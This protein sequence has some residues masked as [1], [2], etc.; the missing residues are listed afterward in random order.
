MTVQCE[1]CGRVRV[2]GEWTRDLFVQS[3]VIGFCKTCGDWQEKLQEIRWRREGRKLLQ[4]RRRGYGPAPEG[5]DP[6]R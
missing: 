3:T 6:F 4:D 1:F 2:N 5:V